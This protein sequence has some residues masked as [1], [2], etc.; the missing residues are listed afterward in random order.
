MTILT[1]SATHVNQFR[2]LDGRFSNI[3]RFIAQTERRQNILDASR[4]IDGDI[5]YLS[6]RKQ[7]TTQPVMRFSEA[8]FTEA[9]KRDRQRPINWVA[10]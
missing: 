8:S 10:A 3:D 2:T 1:Q 4:E 6:P 9:M 5:L 7:A